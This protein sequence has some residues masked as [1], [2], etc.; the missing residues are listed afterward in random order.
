MN[1]DQD[2]RLTYVYNQIAGAVG[3]GQ[4]DFRS[5]MSAALATA[6]GLV[7]LVNSR[8]AG[9]S[10]SIT[11]TKSAALAAIAT[12]P[13]THLDDRQ[14]AAIAE[15][16]ALLVTPALQSGDELTAEEVQSALRHVFAAAGTEPDRTG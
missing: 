6:Q 4:T 15:Q 5:T 10:A 9:L 1:A 7:N 12:I 3:A 16:V 14:I 8:T 11:D 13:A 2:R